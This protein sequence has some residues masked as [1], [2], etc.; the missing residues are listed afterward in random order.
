MIEALPHYEKCFF[1]HYQ[2]GNFGENTEILALLTYSKGKSKEFSK[3]FFSSEEDSIKE[4]AEHIKQLREEGLIL[5]HWCQDGIDFGTVHINLRYK[6]LTGKELGLTYENEINLAY[7]LIRKYGNGYVS[8][9]KL[10]NLGK[11]NN[12]RGIRETELGKGTYNNDR[13]LLIAKIYISAFSNTLKIEAPQ[14]AN[15]IAAPQPI[16]INE[17]RTKKIISETISNIDKQG[18][19]Y[20]FISEYDYNLFAELLTNFFEDKPYKLPETPIQLK[21]TCKTKLAKALGE[22]H[23]ELSNEDKLSTDTDYFRIIRALNHFEK[24]KEG[25]LYKALTR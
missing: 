12:F 1:V 3:T 17:S 14:Q 2:R 19:E 16:N 5:V 22:I 24:V 8:D 23:K 18:W 15:K 13:L 9:P 6:E 25:D 10:D 20:A 21:R 7:W 4:Y 11:L